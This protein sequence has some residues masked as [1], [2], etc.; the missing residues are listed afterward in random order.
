MNRIISTIAIAFA[1]LT[2]ASVHAENF[3]A[4][5]FGG[6]NWSSHKHPGYLVGMDVGYRWCNG[7]RA[8]LE[9]SYRDEHELAGLVNAYYDFNPYPVCNFCL[10]PFVGAGV[11]YAKH[12]F[13]WQLIAGLNYPLQ[14]NIDLSLS[15]RFFNLACHENIHNH[16][17]AL[18]LNYHF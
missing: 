15:Y 18:G 10:A 16:G 11:G 8:E 14:D 17:L 1:I 3:Y 5:V 6:P 4:G 7:I 12:S 2:G 9:G 13:A